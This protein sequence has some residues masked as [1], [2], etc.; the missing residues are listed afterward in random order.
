[1][2]FTKCQNQE[3]NQMTK[4]I[5]IMEREGLIAVINFAT[6]ANIRIMEKTVAFSGFWE[7]NLLVNE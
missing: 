2:T 4:N 5:S 1:M 6:Y 3:E 7:N